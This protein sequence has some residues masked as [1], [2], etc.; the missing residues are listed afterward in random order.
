[1][2]NI[3]IKQVDGLNIAQDEKRNEF[4]KET[5]ETEV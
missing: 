4:I 2:K 5:R 3:L 1:M